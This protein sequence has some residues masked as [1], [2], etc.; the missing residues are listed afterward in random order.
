MDLKLNQ[1][2]SFECLFFSFWIFLTCCN[3]ENVYIAVILIFYG[4]HPNRFVFHLFVQNE[5]FLAEKKSCMSKQKLKITI[6]CFL[7]SYLQK[8]LGNWFSLGLAAEKPY[9]SHRWYS[10]ELT[11]FNWFFSPNRYRAKIS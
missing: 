4:T 9:F 7:Y 6:F 5:L 3:L 11:A 8:I 2:F 10:D 1:K